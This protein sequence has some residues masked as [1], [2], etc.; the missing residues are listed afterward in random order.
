VN[1]KGPRVRSEEYISVI[2][3]ANIDIEGL[4]SRE[5]I[6]CD[7]NPG[8]VF[9]SSGGVGRNI[10]ENIARLGVSTKFF[11]YV[12]DDLN[13]E[14]IIKECQSAG[15]DI[16]HIEILQ[17]ESTGI[18]LSILDKAGDMKAA[19]N[20]MSIYKRMIPSFIDK[21]KAVLE[22][23]AMIVLDTNLPEEV[24]RHVVSTL[25]K[26]RMIIDTVSVAKS[27]KIRSLLGSFHTVKSNRIEAEALTGIRIENNDDMDRA[28][29]FFHSKGV[30]NVYITLG[31]EGTYYSDLASRG[32]MKAGRVSIV[33]ATGAGDAFVAGLVFGNLKAWDI[34]QK[35]RFAMGAALMAMNHVKT[36]NP[37]ISEDAINQM[38]KEVS[39]C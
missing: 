35:T 23:S 3:G 2:G 11:T 30:E 16:G 7:S 26:Q 31:S 32:I 14:V 9:I 12:G 1:V 28:A 36:V 39:L 19:V 6:M 34:R 15:I 22:K 29:G 5:L 24:L 20:D 8:K 4:P 37:F 13:G 21:N 25:K 27:A 18:Y 17:G 38:I 10:A 33:S